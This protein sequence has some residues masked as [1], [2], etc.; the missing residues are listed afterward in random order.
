[1]K[2]I[3]FQIF[4]FLYFV[5]PVF[6]TLGAWADTIPVTSILLFLFF[7]RKSRGLIY[8]DFSFYIYGIIA[9]PF[10]V[11]SLFLVVGG[12]DGM[13]LL[14]TCLKPIRILATLLG[15][16]SLVGLVRIFFPGRE[17]KISLAL[18]AGSFALHGGVMILQWLS[19]EFKDFVYSYT[20]TGDYRSTFEYNF[21]MGGISGQTGGAI[22]SVAQAL[23]FISLVFAF[24]L[25]CAR[26]IFYWIPMGGVIFASIL[27]CGR[28]GILCVAVF[29]LVAT[30]VI[31]T[32]KRRL[33]MLSAYFVMFFFVIFII[34]SIFAFVS[35]SG[36]EDG[37]LF[38]IR[39]ALA[40]NVDFL[41][42]DSGGVGDRFGTIST[43]WGMAHLPDDPLILFFGDLREIYDR[44]SRSD[45]GY[46]RDIVSL[47]LI[48][49][50]FYY[51]PAVWSSIFAIKLSRMNHE[52]SVVAKMF[53]IVVAVIW[54]FHA[55]ELFLYS[56][57]IMSIYSVFY[58]LLIFAQREFLNQQS[59]RERKPISLVPVMPQ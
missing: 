51:L 52:C 47:G 22:L 7:Y 12:I 30:L 37:I 5:G 57:M 28:S 58:A 43:I 29:S 59:L 50:F 33:F 16:Y 41:L 8:L 53:L 23:G 46:I 2:Y 45:I 38:T 36:N 11:G 54:V 14:R 55:K 40:R 18:I 10:I 48:G 6:N 21:R 15:G 39:Y 49:T 17:L 42:N 27:L 9:I 32:L 24:A 35:N 1:M 44:F 19:P 20:T 25:S 26:P 3:F 13:I 56:R 34:S 4:A 31:G